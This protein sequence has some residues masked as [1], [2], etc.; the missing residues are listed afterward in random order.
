MMPYI[1]LAA[2]G[3]GLDSLKIAL[4]IAAAIF[5]L[6]LGR[7]AL[8]LDLDLDLALKIAAAIFTLNVGGIAFSIIGL[9]IGIHFFSVVW[10][11]K[12]QVKEERS[13]ITNDDPNLLPLHLGDK[14]RGGGIPRC[15]KRFCGKICFCAI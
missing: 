4:Q 3:L 7:I 15:K 14:C 8:Q 10:S 5:T 9:G 12:E 2:I 1:V 11:Y 6:N 13:R